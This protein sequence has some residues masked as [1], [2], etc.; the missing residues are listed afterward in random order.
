MRN[1]PRFIDERKREDEKKKPL[2][3]PTRRKS[4]AELTKEK[5]VRI[6][7]LE[8]E[9]EVLVNENEELKGLETTLREMI[10]DLKA[11]IPKSTTWSGEI[12]R[13]NSNLQTKLNYI[14]DKILNLYNECFPEKEGE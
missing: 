6:I 10:K 2:S 1:R 9:V 11:R 4:A 13:K 3:V 14:E 7:Q 12:Q 8:A 5:T